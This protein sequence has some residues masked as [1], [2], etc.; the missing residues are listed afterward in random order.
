MK[1]TASLTEAVALGT[2]LLGIVSGAVDLFVGT[3]A[4]VSRVETLVAFVALEAS[5]V[6][7]LEI[8][9]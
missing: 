3:L 9:M 4:A 6:P 1:H 7:W 8:K 2:E 5:L